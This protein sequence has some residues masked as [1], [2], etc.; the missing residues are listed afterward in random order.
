M[1][2]GMTEL[3]MPIQTDLLR[4]LYDQFNARDMESL[5]AL[6]RNDVVWANGQHGGYVYGRDGV[7]DYWTQ[8][9]KTIDPRVEPLRFSTG[10]D[11][12]IVVAVAQVVRDLE[13]RTLA[14]RTVNHSFQFEDG[15]IRRFDI[16][17]DASHD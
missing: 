3:A 9:W 7:R 4:Q 10:V 11:G 5:L 15:L 2:S 12:A 13:G 17:E 14:E 8:Q 6:M 1:P 16:L